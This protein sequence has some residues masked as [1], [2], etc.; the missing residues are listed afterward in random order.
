MENIRAHS[1]R[2]IIRGMSAKKDVVD[3]VAGIRF[4]DEDQFIPYSDLGYNSE[5]GYY[6]ISQFPDAKNE[7]TPENHEH[8]HPYDNEH[9]YEAVGDDGKP[10]EAY[11]WIDGD[12][13]AHLLG[14]IAQVADLYNALGDLLIHGKHQEEKIGDNHPVWG[15]PLSISQAVDMA[16]E[17]DPDKYPINESTKANIRAA[18]VAGR[19][20]AEKDRSNRWIFPQYEFW[21]WLN[22]DDMHKSGPKTSPIEDL[23]TSGSNTSTIQHTLAAM[24]REATGNIPRGQLWQPCE[25]HGCHNEPVCLNC[26]E[27]EE[28]HCN[29]FD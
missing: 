3:L 20:H 22:D 5:L 11:V 25:R 16:N 19:L 26:L 9:D 23:I 7:T 15:K 10:W 21:Q 29:C 4:T 13:F 8:I 12:G 17:H 14:D 28:T 27:C 6:Q 24:S 2:S 18:A 1:T